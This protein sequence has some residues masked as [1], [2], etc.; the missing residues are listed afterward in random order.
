MFRKIA[1]ILLGVWLL[2][3]TLV[4]VNAGLSMMNEKSDLFVIGG[5][6]LAMLA[7]TGVF[8]GFKYAISRLWKGRNE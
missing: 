4:L 5:V 2:I 3:L 1:A 8:L 7:G 6:T